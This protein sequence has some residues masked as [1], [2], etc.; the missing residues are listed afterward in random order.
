MGFKARGLRSPTLDRD[1]LEEEGTGAAGVARV[2]GTAS[3]VPSRRPC[4]W[5]CVQEGWRRT[6]KG[7]RTDPSELRPVAGSGGDVVGLTPGGQL[8]AGMALCL[9]GWRGSCSWGRAM[10]L[11]TVSQ[12]Y[13]GEM[14]LAR[15]GCIKSRR[16]APCL[17]SRGSRNASKTPEWFREL[18]NDK[19]E[20]TLINAKWLPMSPGE[21]PVNYK[22]TS[23]NLGGHHGFYT[24][25]RAD[26]REIQILLRQIPKRLAGSMHWFFIALS[27]VLIWR[28]AGDA[29]ATKQEILKPLLDGVI[30]GIITSIFILV[31][32]ALWKSNI[33]AWIQNIT[34]RDAR[35]E[36]V[37]QGFLIPFIGIREI[38][39]MRQQAA[40]AAIMAQMLERANK[41]KANGAITVE[42]R[43]IT[44]SKDEDEDEESDAELYLPPIEQKSDEKSQT[45]TSKQDSG[46][47]V[48]TVTVKVSVSPIPIK[49]RAELTRIGNTIKGR[50]I[51]I[52]GASEVHTYSLDGSFRNLMLCGKYESEN[53]Q[54]IDRGSFSL[55]LKNNGSMLEGFFAAY[56]TQEGERIHP[57]RCELRRNIAGSLENK[58]L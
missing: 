51:E 29:F 44:H 23:R 13:R 18:S 21:D 31:F 5:S 2:F 17:R 16:L 10:V 11:R 54:N 42:A 20:S 39:Q 7:W 6:W 45:H 24:E 48:K 8:A 52:G 33:T 32:S 19:L 1:D 3:G 9:T 53:P 25:A 55:M 49:M 15:A 58:A 46:R 38:D 27:T 36:G 12:S 35:I 14:G 41:E 56:T 43:E 30:S 26:I 22:P 34:Y 4:L 57:F 28:W 47:R 50:L 40:W 37:W